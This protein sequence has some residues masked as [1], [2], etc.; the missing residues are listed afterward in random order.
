[1]PDYKK[2]YFALCRANAQAAD[3]LLRA[4]RQ[5]EEELLRDDPPPLRLNDA[6]PPQPDPARPDKPPQ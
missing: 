2:L 1:M 3:L 6:Q 4:A 5:A